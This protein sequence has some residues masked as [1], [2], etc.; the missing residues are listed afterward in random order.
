MQA[1]L[2]EEYKQWCDKYFYL[3]AWGEHRGVGGI[4]FDD[5]L[6]SESSLDAEQVLCSHSQPCSSAYQSSSYCLTC[7]TGT[8]TSVHSQITHQL[9]I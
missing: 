6:S 9:Q 8:G 7:C 3:P 1:G 2:Y 4:F 5:L